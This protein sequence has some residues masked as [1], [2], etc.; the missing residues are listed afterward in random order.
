MGTNLLNW[1][2]EVDAMPK[3]F[4]REPPVKKNAVKAKGTDLRVSFKNTYNTARATKSMT[5]NDARN[6]LNAALEKQRIIP[7]RKFCGSQGRH[8]QAKEFGL[9]KGRWPTKSIKIVLGLIDNMIANANSKSLDA[10]NLVI[11]HVQI[12]KAPNG[13]RRT[14]RAHGRITPFMSHPCHVEMWASLKSEG[15]A[16]NKTDKGNTIAVSRVQQARSRVQQRL[17]EG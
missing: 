6:F 10:E 5:L 16:K 12:N 9:T 8:A 4:A 17:R 13:R 15:V 1:S 11:N 2:L 3:K 14:Y 7:M